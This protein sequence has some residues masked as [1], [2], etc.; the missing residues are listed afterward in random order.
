MQHTIHLV[1]SFASKPFTGNPAA[2]CLIGGPVDEQWMQQTAMEMNQAETAFLMPE[3]GGYRLRWFTPV[4]EVE[5]C[6]HATLAA[7]HTLWEVG[8]EPVQATIEF[9]TLSGKLTARIVDGWIELD[10]PAERESPCESP[11]DGLL[12]S[13]G[14]QSPDILYIGKNRFDYIVQVGN[15]NRIRQLAPDF[16]ALAQ[17][18]CR[19]VMV[20]AIS[21]TAEYDFISRFFGPSAGIDEDAAT[22]SAHCCLAPFWQGRLQKQQMLGYQASKRGAF[23][24]VEVRGD[25][26][27]LAGQAVTILRGELV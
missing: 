23:V 26:V 17:V 5:L 14:I 15:A 9:H 1:D 21:D 10:F 18:P 8:T 27:I 2:V 11:P 12:A 20:T 16:A 24:R 7:A 6:G 25:R 22:G 19:G 3:S 13:L 4:M